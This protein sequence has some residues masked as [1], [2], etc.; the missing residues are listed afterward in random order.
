MM[1]KVVEKVILIAAISLTVG[2]QF[3]RIKS[4]D[5]DMGGIEIEYHR[6]A[7]V[8]PGL[9]GSA[10]IKATPANWPRLLPRNIEQ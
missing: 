4:F 10:P 7:D 9:F 2:C 6:P 1:I 8:E 5:L 3:S